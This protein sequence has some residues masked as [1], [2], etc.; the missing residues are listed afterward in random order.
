MTPDDVRV[1]E[2]SWSELR[3]R[4]SALVVGLAGVLEAEA[5]SEIRA[6]VRAAW[7]VD[8]VDE[9]VG[10]LPTPSRLAVRAR[11]LGVT[12]PDPLT[13][14]SYR[15]EGRGWIQ[16]AAGCVPT[17]SARTE[18]AWRHAWLLLSDVL[19][20]EMLSPFTDGVDRAGH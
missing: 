6:D 3:P 9:L 8:A 13:A 17:W 15:V 16:A 12:W 11:D 2:R 4:R 5:P 14:P 18:A 7:L 19:A 20:A 10:L 1:V